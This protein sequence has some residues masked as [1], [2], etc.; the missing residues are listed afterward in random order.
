MERVFYFFRRRL[1]LLGQVVFIPV[2]CVAICNVLPSG[3]D[4]IGEVFVGFDIGVLVAKGDKAI[5]VAIGVIDAYPDF[6]VDEG[7]GI[8]F[9]FLVGGGCW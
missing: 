2:G 3:I 6:R 7:R 9:Y 4:E 8:K 5:D 1:R